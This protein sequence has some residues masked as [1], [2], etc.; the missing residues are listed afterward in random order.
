MESMNTYVHCDPREVAAT[1]K[2]KGASM[3]AGIQPFIIGTDDIHYSVPFKCEAI[4][5]MYGK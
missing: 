1:N 4:K 3:E 5:C 2:Q